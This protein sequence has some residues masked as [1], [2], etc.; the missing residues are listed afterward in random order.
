[1]FA[2]GKTT[3]LPLVAVLSLPFVA[4]AALPGA[5]EPA[6]APEVVRI[7]ESSITYRLPGEYLV[8][9]TA[10]NA[11]LEKISLTR[12]FEIMR[13]QVTAGEYGRCVAAGGCL[14]LDAPQ[15][16]EMPVVGVNWYDAAAYAAWFS[17]ETGERWRLPSDRE[18]ALAAGS[19][20]RD[21]ALTDVADAQDP[22]RRWIALYE[23]ET[24]RGAEVD[25][26]PRP[27]GHFGSNEH[28]LLDMGG[29]VWEWT[30]SC[31]LRHRFDPVTDAESVVENCGIRI[32]QG[33]HRAYMTT[34]F[35]DPKAG[36]CSVGIP[37]ANLGIRLVR[38]EPGALQRL[39][40]WIGL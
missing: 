37:P 23:A 31:Y 25:P 34:F 17:R 4:G 22:S 14:A 19:R 26:A 33:S 28:G 40:T 11:P 21:D 2:K 1:M 20:Y 10:T 13:R 5:A 32:A 29:N 36:A 9:R 16:P 27:V 15:D 39:K 24:A 6:G 12:P 3:L 18:W 30:D 8:G 7:E 38:D 35:R